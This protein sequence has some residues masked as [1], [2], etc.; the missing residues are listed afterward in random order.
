MK[1]GIMIASSAAICAVGLSQEPPVPP[2]PQT[3]AGSLVSVWNDSAW[4]RFRI[5][6]GEVGQ[7]NQYAVASLEGR[8]MNVRGR[9]PGDGQV[10]YFLNQYTFTQ[11]VAGVYLT[12]VSAFYREPHMQVS[13]FF[14]NTEIG[15][16][17]PRDLPLDLK[18]SDTVKV[19]DKVTVAVRSTDDKDVSNV[20]SFAV[21]AYGKGVPGPALETL[22]PAATEAS[23]KRMYTGP[24]EPGYKARHEGQQTEIEKLRPRVIFIGD[25]IT[26]GFDDAG[27]E[28]WD[29]L[30]RF[31]PAN[32]GISGDWTQ[33]VLWRVAH[34]VIGKVKPDLVVLMIGTNN[35]SYPEDEVAA[36]I[37]A[38]ID[39]IRQMSPG[40]KVLLHGILPRGTDYPKGN[41]YEVINEKISRF[42][43][44][45]SVIWMDMSEL[46]LTP[47]RR[48]RADLLPD[49]LHPG[50][51]GYEVWAKSIAPKL[52]EI[53]SS[54]R[55]EK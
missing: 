30:K 8:R 22:H 11:E 46:F 7:T 53:L 55:R 12:H 37:K 14:N 41:R 29:T 20:L 13:V 28:Y 24:I 25:S 19:G 36:G 10:E 23:P 9:K 26:D 39:L 6:G 5:K 40:T 27:R 17:A 15:R 38:I 43:D 48:V 18:V 16:F 34:S 32:M 1:R 2:A 54:V 45:S 52:E 44:G 4:A 51:K 33:N 49:G 50:A 31:Q 35:G 3:P 42:A 21:E 47:D